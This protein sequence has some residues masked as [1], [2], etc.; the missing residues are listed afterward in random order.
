MFYFLILV[1]F[2]LLFSIYDFPPSFSLRLLQVDYT[3]QDSFPKGGELC[4]DFI[5]YSPVATF[6]NTNLSKHLK[7]M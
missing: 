4:P 3:I 6:P 2:A 1:V 7:F 5:V